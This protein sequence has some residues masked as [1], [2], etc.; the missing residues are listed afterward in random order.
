MGTSFLESKLLQNIIAM[1][2]EVLYEVFLDLKKFTMYY[3]GKGVWK[4]CWRIDPSHINSDSSASTDS[5]SQWYTWQC[6][7]MQPCSRSPGG[8]HRET[9][10]HPP[11][12][13]CWWTQSFSTGLRGWM[14]RMRG[15]ISS[16]GR[17]K[18]CLSSSMRTTVYQCLHVQPGFRKP[19]T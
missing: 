4:F 17:C 19:C 5:S 15:H 6:T 11:Y 12:L 13:I 18:N 2:E 8:S 7:S 3:I 10:C 9:L 16:V 1:R 14:W